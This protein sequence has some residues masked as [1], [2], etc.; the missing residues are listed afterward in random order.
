MQDLRKVLASG[1]R[2]VWR[3][4]LNI[5]ACLLWVPWR[6]ACLSRVLKDNNRLPQDVGLSKVMQQDEVSHTL[7][8]A[9]RPGSK[10]KQG[11]CY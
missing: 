9:H 7:R 4:I 8:C 3:D 10:T 11:R 6:H 1:T 2:A 5:T